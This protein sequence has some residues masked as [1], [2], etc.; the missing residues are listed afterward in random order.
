MTIS[1]VECENLISTARH[2]LRN[3]TERLF[4]P[5]WFRALQEI[6]RLSKP[7]WQPATPREVLDH[8]LMPAVHQLAEESPEQEFLTWLLYH[9]EFPRL[10]AL[11]QAMERAE[12]TLL[13]SEDESPLIP[14]ATRL[15]IRLLTARGDRGWS[16]VC[17][18]HA[19]GL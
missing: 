5:T 15:A 9:A 17:L 8:L 18:Q 3:R 1:D 7:G 12:S 13:H 10:L 11:W 14:T 4:P 6:E 19:C 16:M 2:E